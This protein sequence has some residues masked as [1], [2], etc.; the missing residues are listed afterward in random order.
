[1]R[2][3]C[4]ILKVSK[5]LLSQLLDLEND[6][7]ILHIYSDPEDIISGTFKILLESPSLHE[8]PEDTKPPIISHNK[9]RKNV[10]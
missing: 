7:N 2:R 4:G 10:L 1:M 8:L 6:C 5:E 3:H 9:I